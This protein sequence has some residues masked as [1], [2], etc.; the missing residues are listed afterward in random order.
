MLARSL[1]VIVVSFGLLFGIGEKTLAREPNW[2][3][4]V[5]VTGAER[6]RIQATPIHR[7]PYRPFHF[8]GNAARRRYYRGSMMP[9]PRDLV[10]GFRSLVVRR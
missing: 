10:Q 8:Y 3:G 5:I 6:S 2:S 1:A 4:R 9:R 7:R